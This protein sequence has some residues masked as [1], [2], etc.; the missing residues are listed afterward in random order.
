MFTRAESP[1]F[2]LDRLGT[3]AVVF[4]RP[5][6]GKSSFL[7]WLMRGMLR[8]GDSRHLLPLFVRLRD[9]AKARRS[10][11]GLELLDFALTDVCGIRDPRQ[12]DLWIN[13]LRCLAGPSRNTVL[14]LLDGWDELDPGERDELDPELDQYNQDF[15]M[16]LTSRHTAP[17]AHVSPESYFEIAE[18]TPSA[19]DELIERWFAAM[20]RSGQAD[21]L[22]TLLARQRELAQLARNPFTATLLCAIAYHEDPRVP[23]QLPATRSKIYERTIA[24]IVSQY[25]RD[26]KRSTT[27]PLDESRLRAVGRLAHWLYELAPAAPRHVFD[28]GDVERAT[29]DLDLLPRVLDPSRLICQVDGRYGNYQFVHTTY[30]EYFVARHLE[31]MPAH[32]LE[33]CLA[34]HTFDSGW[35]VVGL[36]L[37]GAR[38]ERELL[39]R[40]IGELLTR[41]DRFGH[42]YVRAAWLLA[43]AE[44]RDGGKA[45]LGVDVR[46]ELW[47]GIVRGVQPKVFRD[48]YLL[49]DT[50]D[51]VTRTIAA[52]ASDDSRQAAQMSR[53]LRELP[54][55]RAVEKLREDLASDDP[56]RAS[57][58]M[59]GGERV[60]TA[61]DLAQLRASVVDERAPE[62]LRTRIIALLGNLHDLGALPV[63]EQL[64]RRGG[65]LVAAAIGAIGR[66]GGE[67][68]AKVLCAL[69][70]AGQGPTDELH[71]ALGASRSVRG[72]NALL[73]ALAGCE[74]NHE[75]VPTLLESLLDLPLGTQ[76]SVAIVQRHLEQS[77]Q[78]ST[79]VIAANVL[80]S[81]TVA[82]AGASLARRA[83]EDG[84]LE[85][86]VAALAALA[87]HPDPKHVEWLRALSRDISK[88]PDER[89][90]ALTAMLVTCARF[91]RSPQWAHLAGEALVEVELA[92]TSGHGGIQLAAVAKA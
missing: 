73:A 40:M 24:L 90:R 18:L 77:E 53:L 71:A 52:S 82:E 3:G 36:F 69:L 14:L 20:D 75:D 13:A 50:E 38:R 28:G 58:A 34:E 9:F 84:D 31:T 76:E 72:R 54:S 21:E 67:Q 46:D 10:R 80:A 11:P 25:E 32:E 74:P 4:G 66:V 49:L 12:R 45:L 59:Y 86:R 19:S 57:L 6:S 61:L 56:K 79:R 27:L 1:E 16:I 51:L 85:V 39:Q 2:V 48:A 26:R 33:Q 41:I 22:R 5:G 44:V 87:E 65:P 42:V 63:L 15:A 78:A 92:L 55:P 60:F 91:A 83:R 8:G 68:A 7:K 88:D 62:R 70:D 89:E 17:P 64:V 47:R 23:L 37:A 35:L 29:H 81:A 43:E 30:H